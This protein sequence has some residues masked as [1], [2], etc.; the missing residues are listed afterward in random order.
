MKTLQCALC[1]Q[2]ITVTM[3]GEPPQPGV[4]TVDEAE[5][6]YGWGASGDGKVCCKFHA[7]MARKQNLR[8]VV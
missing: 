7:P 3:P 5:S 6:R 2:R 1:S 8:N 4:P